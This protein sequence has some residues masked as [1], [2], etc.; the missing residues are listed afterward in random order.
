MRVSLGEVSGGGVAVQ[1]E[2]DV[3]QVLV[4]QELGE[5]LDM[6]VDAQVGRHLLA[7]AVTLP[8]QRGG[9]DGVADPVQRPAHVAPAPRTGFAP[10][11]STNVAMSSTAT[12]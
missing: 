12:D 10:C 2:M 1:D 9:E 7:A 4:P 11:T 5:V 6:G 3:V 8:R